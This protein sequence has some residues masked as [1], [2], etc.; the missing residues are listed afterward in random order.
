MNK[1]LDL[2]SLPPEIRQKVEA[3]LAKLSPEVRRQWEAQ[4]SPML[5]RLV[6]RLA[7]KL[8]APPAPGSLF[9]RIQATAE[10]AAQARPGGRPRPPRRP[11]PRPPPPPPPNPPPPPPQ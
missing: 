7:G 3:G 2:A 4:G 10:A 8:P 1:K 9:Q 11:P 5:D 6:A